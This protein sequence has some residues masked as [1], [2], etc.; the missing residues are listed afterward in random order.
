[1]VGPSLTDEERHAANGRLR[2][3]FVLLVGVSAGLVALQ[4]DP[5]PAQIVGAVVAGLVVGWALLYWLTRSLRVG[6]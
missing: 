1:M 4:V 3:G 5:T 2:F 6:F